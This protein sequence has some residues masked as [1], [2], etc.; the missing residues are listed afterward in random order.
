MEKDKKDIYFKVDFKNLEF[1][2]KN[3]KILIKK[4]SNLRKKADFFKTSLKIDVLH[5]GIEDLHKIKNKYEFYIF[6]A[7]KA[8]QIDDKKERCNFLYYEICFFLDQVCISN[9]LCEFKN[10]KCFVKQNSDVTMG[11][12]H[13]YPNKKLGIFYQHK[14]IPCEYLGDRGCTTKAIGC[15]LYMCP[16]VNKKGYKFTVNNV[17]L[18]KYFFNFM[19]KLV[20]ISGIFDTKENIMKRLLMFNY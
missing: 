16:E 20:I 14:M 2:E 18:I 19:Q 11:C 7:I 1:N 6:T 17:L 15:K 10:N 9:N 8:V 3:A 4:L 12:C 13:H 5:K